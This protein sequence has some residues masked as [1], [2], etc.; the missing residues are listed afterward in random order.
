MSSHEPEAAVGL[1]SVSEPPQ[2]A[3]TSARPSAAA[4]AAIRSPPRR[5]TP[6]RPRAG[7]RVPALSTFASGVRLRIISPPQECAYCASLALRTRTALI[8]TDGGAVC[9]CHSSLELKSCQVLYIRCT[10]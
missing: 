5:A 8:A 6:R 7:S 2:A 9:E 1:L 3:V 10:A 4:V